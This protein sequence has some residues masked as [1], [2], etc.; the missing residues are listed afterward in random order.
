MATPNLDDAAAKP[1][2]VSNP[3]GSVEQHDLNEQI[4]YDR[5][6]A[7]NKAASANARRGV[8]FSKTILGGPIGFTQQ[9]EDS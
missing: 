3:V 4:E 6:K 9:S 5:H 7:A 1:A 2:K 8:M